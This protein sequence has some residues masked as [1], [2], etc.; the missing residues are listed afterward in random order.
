MSAHQKPIP[1][2]LS[3]HDKR[4]L[5]VGTAKHNPGKV[6][7]ECEGFCLQSA[8]HTPGQ[9]RCLEDRY[10]G[11]L[12]YMVVGA[13]GCVLFDSINRGPLPDDAARER[14]D[15][16]MAARAPDLLE[17]LQPFVAHNSSEETVTITVRTADVTRARALIASARGE[18]A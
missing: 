12:H 1:T 13:D 11:E 2:A 17:A 8:Q 6:C 15:M 9:W 14:A 10:S 3:A 16:L 5:R 18:A 7:D 4:R